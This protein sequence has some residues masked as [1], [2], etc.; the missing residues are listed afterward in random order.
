[1]SLSSSTA[2]TV[3]I[4]LVMVF[5]V[6]ALVSAEDC[7]PCFYNLGR[8]NTDGNGTASDGRPK[9]IVQID[10]SWNVNNAGQAQATTNANIW[11]GVVG[12]SSCIPRM[13][14]RV[15]GIARKAHRACLSTST[16]S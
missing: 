16:L 2:R 7:P 13:A 4:V 6:F 15:C 12:C 9:L 3:G 14:Q 11:N 5:C 1:M 10:S 8:P